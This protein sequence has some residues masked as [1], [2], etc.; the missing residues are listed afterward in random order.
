MAYV[1]NSPSQQTF[2][3]GMDQFS[4]N[5]SNTTF[6]LSRSV[7]TAYDV[8][9]YVESV[10]QRPGVAYTVSANT[11]TFTS[12]PS[13]GSNNVV[14]VYNSYNTTSIVP[15]E[16]SVSTRHLG[17]ITNINAGTNA[18]LTLQANNGTA[19]AIT[20]AANVGIGTATPTTRLHAYTN[21]ATNN[22]IA[23]FQNDIATPGYLGELIL[24]APNRPAVRWNFQTSNDSN[25]YY[26]YDTGVHKW[27]GDASGSAS[28]IMRA[29]RYGIGLGSNTPS[30][31]MGIMFPATQV[32]SSDPNT[33]DDYEEGTWT[34]TVKGGST[35][36]VFTGLSLQGHYIKI[37]NQVTAWFIMFA[38]SCTSAGS[39]GAYVGGLP[40]A[41][42]HTYRATG[43]V[44]YC[45][46]LGQSC[47]SGFLEVGNN[48]FLFIQT[49]TQSAVTS[50]AVTSNPRIFFTVTYS[51]S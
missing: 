39:G 48:Q 42:S 23:K 20:A 5:A 12:A 38:S 7:N 14:V 17:T 9:V 33:L 8:D 3:G 19:I 4:G 27:F 41:G 1:G 22:T 28:E 11:I 16:G 21:V 26:T 45:G 2:T 13:A 24:A 18:G 10:F 47:A 46:G 40:F 44:T 6:G 51:L 50:Y 37:G 25:G 30:S 32:A 15:V 43:T 36:P 31:G 35:D 34:P 49:G 29:N